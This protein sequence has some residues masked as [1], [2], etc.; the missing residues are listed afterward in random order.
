MFLILRAVLFQ[1][2]KIKFFNVYESLFVALVAFFAF[3]E[4]LWS[5]IQTTFHSKVMVSS[6]LLFPLSR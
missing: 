5:K 2:P 6:A 1:F 3:A 4:T